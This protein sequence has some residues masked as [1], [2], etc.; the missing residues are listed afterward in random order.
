MQQKIGELFKNSDIDSVLLITSGHN[1]DTNFYYFTQLSQK[2]E[3]S[4]FLVFRKGKKPLLITDPREYAILKTYRNFDTV[5][6]RNQKE[7]VSILNKAVG[8]KVG[9]DHN[10][11]S[12]T[13]Y[14][15]IRKLLKKR[16]FADISEK[17]NNLR[18]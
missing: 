13:R 7:L 12:L 10:A 1:V 18:S 8:K 9:I 14:K 5:L 15:N 4:G 16:K 17:F 3:V 11:I 6:Y 2:K